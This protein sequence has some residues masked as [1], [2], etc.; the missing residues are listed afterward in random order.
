MYLQVK[1]T[2]EIKVLK[3]KRES[4]SQVSL[5]ISLEFVVFKR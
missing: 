2:L 5:Q 4:K 1:I 3:V